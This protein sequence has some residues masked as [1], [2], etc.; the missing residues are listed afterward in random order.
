MFA[1]ELLL[2][3]GLALKQPVHG[4]V[5]LVLVGVGDI[6]VFGQCRRVPPAG[7]RQ[8]GMGRNNP[9]GHHR[10]NDVAF[11]TRLGGDQGR[12]AEPLHGQ[13]DGFDRPL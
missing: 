6:E 2:D 3:L 4:G 12:K 5:E 7:R 10:Q 1:G 8:L 11:A 9:R 13:R